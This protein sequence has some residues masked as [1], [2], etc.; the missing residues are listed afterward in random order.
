MHGPDSSQHITASPLT[1]PSGWKRE[2][3]KSTSRFNNPTIRAA[4]QLVLDQLRMMG[5]PDYNVIISTNLQLR[6]DGLPYSNQRDP[7]DKGVAVWWKKK[8]AQQ[9]IALDRYTRIAD[10]LYA[11]GKTL[12]AMRGI[13]RWGG[14]EILSRTFT[15][16]VALPDQSH[17]WR[18][19]LGNPVTLEEAEQ[20]FKRLRATAHPDKGGTPEQ[21]IAIRQAWDQAI[22]EF[23]Q[24]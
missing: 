11:I 17:D 22:Q 4:T 21:F 6:R 5:V 19:I 7:E 2:G 13:E 9:V 23:G 24:P 18:A 8:G 3:S 16:F 15:G 14:G 1:W 12:D 10:N 20:A